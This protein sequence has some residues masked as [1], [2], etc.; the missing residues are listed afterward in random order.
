MLKT[1]MDALSVV[2]ATDIAG[3]SRLEGPALPRLPAVR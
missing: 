1:V 2:S 3:A